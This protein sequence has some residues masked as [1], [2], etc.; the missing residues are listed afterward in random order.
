MEIEGYL[1]TVVSSSSLLIRICLTDA[2]VKVHLRMLDVREHANQKK[3]GITST[4][5]LL[6]GTQAG[7]G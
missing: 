5:R 6:P 1:V 4:C 7:G 3:G 2:G